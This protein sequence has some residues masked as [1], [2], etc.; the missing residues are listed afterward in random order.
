MLTFVLVSSGHIRT[1]LAIFHRPGLALDVRTL[2]RLCGSPGSGPVTDQPCGHLVFRPIPAQ[3]TGYMRKFAAW[4]G[5]PAISFVGSVALMYGRH[6]AKVFNASSERRDRSEKLVGS[7]FFLKSLMDFKQQGHLAFVPAMLPARFVLLSHLVSL[8]VGFH[9]C[10]Q[11]STSILVE[12]HPLPHSVCGWF[13]C[14][15]M[16]NMPSKT[17]AN[18]SIPFLCSSSSSPSSHPVNNLGILLRPLSGL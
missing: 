16:F 5:L 6:G 10:H 17:E 4:F 2:R 15:G 11:P 3:V 1:H 14:M 12:H 9:V 7:F 13:F 8:R 18:R